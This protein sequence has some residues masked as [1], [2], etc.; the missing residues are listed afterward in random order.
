ME[1]TTKAFDAV[2]ESRKW[3][4]TTS[5]KLDAMTTDECITYLRTL[6]EQY[7]SEHVSRHPKRASEA[8]AAA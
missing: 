4:E 2:A 3:R 5:R 8:A 7:A 6:G 1:A